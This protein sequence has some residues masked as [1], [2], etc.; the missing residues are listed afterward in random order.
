[1]FAGHSFKKAADAVRR[2]A[3]RPIPLSSNEHYICS[4]CRVRTAPP[5]YADCDG[6]WES[7]QP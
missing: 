3:R 1:M 6:C 5:G 4:T 7:H 2:L